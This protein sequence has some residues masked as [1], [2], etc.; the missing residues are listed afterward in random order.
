MRISDWSSDV[1]SS[2]LRRHVDR[3]VA[4]F[5]ASVGAAARF[6]G[7]PAAFTASRGGFLLRRQ[8]GVEVE[9]VDGQ[10]GLDHRLG[11]GGIDRELSVAVDL[12]PLQLYLGVTHLCA[13]PLVPKSV[14]WGKSM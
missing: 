13:R 10:L 7:R 12:V 4:P 14:V 11:A 5:A 8:V 3:L 1:C 2:D 9:L 6:A